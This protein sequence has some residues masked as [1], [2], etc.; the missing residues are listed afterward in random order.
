MDA[1]E[2]TKLY[3]DAEQ[4]ALKEAD[5]HFRR[6]VELEES[7][8]KELPRVV[9]SRCPFDHQPLYRTFDPFGLDGPWWRGDASP[10]EPVACRHFLVL[11][12]ALSFNGRPAQAGSF[13]VRPGP[14]VPFVIPRLLEKEGVKAV[15]SMLAMENGYVA[16]PVAYFAER[17]PPPQEL[18]A[19][20]GRTLYLYETQLGE[21]SWRVASE[22]R[23]FELD[24]WLTSGK[25]LWT[26]GNGDAMRL[27]QGT[28]CPHAGLR[29]ERRP[30]VLEGDRVWFDVPHGG[31]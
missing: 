16:Y 15:V 17:R 11:D 7:Y 13:E 27:K 8:L 24:P 25:L 5:E 23:D 31:Q 22:V 6:A 9:M 29:G 12:G 3:T 1:M 18:T 21:T 20:W 2:M 26:S 4:A 14:Q 10:E 28:D 30:A 19:T